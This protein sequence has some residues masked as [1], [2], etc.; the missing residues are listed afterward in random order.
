MADRARD[1]QFRVLSDTSKLD[2]DGAARDLD[3]LGDMGKRA[4]DKLDDSTDSARK[5]LGHYADD[6]RDVARKIGRAF[7]DISDASRKSA[8]K[9]DDDLDDAKRGLDEFKDEAHSSGREAAASFGGGFDD[10]T[11]FVQE[12]AANAFSGFGPIGAI[13]GTAAAVGIGIIG[14]AFG[15][16]KERSEEARESVT[17]W[18]NAYVEGLGTIQEAT[19]QANLDKFAEDGGKKLREYGDAARDAGVDVAD[20]L[21]AQ[22]GD[23]DAQRRVADQYREQSERLAELSQERTADQGAIARQ[24]LALQKVAENLGYTNS[25]MSE[26]KARADELREATNRPMQLKIITGIDIPS[27]AE[28]DKINRRVRAGIGT[29]PVQLRVVGQSKFANTSNNDRYRW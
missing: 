5:S 28:L 24:S 16:A 14:K 11:D 8:R 4:L 26:A 19:I 12:T 15:D 9:I 6:A 7:G 23:Q 1:L 3:N 27:P 21:R 2:L 18:I 22:A 10:I 20:Y 13:A 29:I 25:K 17:E